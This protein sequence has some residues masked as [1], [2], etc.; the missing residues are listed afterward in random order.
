MCDSAIIVLM[1]SFGIQLLASYDERSFVGLAQDIR[2][3]NYFESLPK[4]D[5]TTIKRRILGR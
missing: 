3:K 4:L 2:G 5:Q 1:N